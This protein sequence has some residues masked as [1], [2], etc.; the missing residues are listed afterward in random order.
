MSYL[1]DTNVVSE[2][3]RR[4][5]EP[6]VLAWFGRAD[7]E[8]L[9]L[10]VLTLGEIAKGA[11]SLSRRDPA[12]GGSLRGWLDGLRA[13][14]ADRLIGI[15]ALVAEE[16]G[17]LSAART[18]PVIDGLLAATALVHGLALVT[19]NGS[20]VVDTGVAVINPWQA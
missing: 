16:W 3:R 11:A 5:P 12:A 9:Y 8:R 20:D 18:L 19:R 2:L 15:D 4:V 13:H 17:R 1:L 14:Y 7:P 10:S 6:K